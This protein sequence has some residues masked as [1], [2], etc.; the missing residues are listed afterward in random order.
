MR[1]QNLKVISEPMRTLFK[2]FPFSFA[3]SVFFLFAGNSLFAADHADPAFVHEPV[4]GLAIYGDLKYAK[5]FQHFD[6][7]N[8]QAPKGGILRMESAGT[9]DSFNPFVIKGQA[10]EGIQTLG[11][12]TL[13]ARSSDESGSCYGYL[14][15]SIEVAP[16]RSWVVFSLRSDATFHDGTPIRADDVVY[17]FNMLIQKGMP[18]YKGY[19][20]TV[21]KAEKLGERKV[22]FILES[23]ASRELPSILGEFPVFSKS[24]MTRQGFEKSDLSPPLGSGPY[25]V[26]VFQAGRFVTY[27]RI[28]NWW[29]EKIPVNVGRYNFD[30]I[31]YDYF[32]DRNV[33]FE[34][35]KSHVFDLHI[36][37]AAKNWVTGY[38]FR[39]YKE[40]K[41]VKEE[42]TDRHP[43]AMQGVVYNTRRPL[44]QDRKV[45]QA[46]THAF[47]FEWLNKYLFYNAYRRTK[48]FFD[49]SELAS[50]G[51]PQG[52]ELKLLA[53]YKDQLP[54]EVLTEPFTL[55]S[56]ETSSSLRK[57][58]EKAQ[59]M[60]A[61]A[62]WRVRDNRLIHTKTGAPFIFEIL[63]RQPDFERVLQGFVTHLK[64]LGVE[65][66][67][68]TVDSSQ[69]TQRVENYDFDMI[70][71]VIPQS[72]TPG[73]EQREF[74][75]S[76]QANVPGGLNLAG[77]SDPVIDQ[78]VELVI[79][80]PDKKELLTRV[81]ALDRVLLWGY[82]LI[83]TWHSAGTRIAYWR[84]LRHPDVF[85]PYGLD[86]M[87]WWT[88][89]PSSSEDLKGLN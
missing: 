12:A 61:E 38:D 77:V 62:G 65:A 82:Y 37:T 9:F 16:D 84:P 57:N 52:D 17:S 44:F 70:V 73:N 66:R 20:K 75:L 13:T 2:S 28:K 36:E 80:A 83:P 56:M 63:L 15:E 43:S 4:H 55:P 85:P 74:W 21:K 86:L 89:A 68:R 60:L 72:S 54:A 32:R 51:L 18:F 22:R 64:R 35:F 24:F 50:S 67:L 39:A 48:S 42:T 14:A 1:C 40:G 8:P 69:Y 87:C 71:G 34:A 6:Y 88:D 79:N 41:V 81:H 19:Y 45:R 26:G 76:S 46:L 10:A 78:L 7:V 49:R 30:Q 25:K 31:R 53:S 23:G 29:G 11:Y 5:D 59:K 33:A 3:L 58:L 47:D 27:E